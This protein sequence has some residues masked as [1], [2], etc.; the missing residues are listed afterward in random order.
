MFPRG[1]VLEIVGNRFNYAIAEEDI[2]L[3]SLELEDAT[4]SLPP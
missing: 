1:V 2:E 4:Q 3:D